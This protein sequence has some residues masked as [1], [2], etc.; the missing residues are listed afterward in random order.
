ME[1]VSIIV[2]VKELEWAE[3]CIE[4]LKPL[5]CKVIQGIQDSF[6]KVVNKIILE[7]TKEIMIMCS[8]RVRPTP[9]DIYKMLDLIEQG[10]G[11]VTLFRL[12]C[13]GFKRDLFRHINLFDERFLI[14]GYEDVC[15]FIRLQEANIAYYENECIPYIK[16]TST[17]VH[18]PGKL[19]SLVHFENKWRIDNQNRTIT[20]K[21][22]ETMDKSGL[23][24]IVDVNLRFKPWSDSHLLYFSSWHSNYKI[25]SNK[26]V[27]G[28]LLIFG[29]TGSLGNKIIQRYGF[30]NK[31]VVYSRD[32]LKQSTLKTMY[33]NL[34]I[35]FVLGDIRDSIRVCEII[36]EINPSV[37]IIASALKQI[38][39]VEYDINEALQT[40]T[41]GI[42]NICRALKMN[43]YNLKIR[44][45]IYISTDKSC[46][47][48]TVYGMTKSL[49]ERIMV[50]YSKKVPEISFV[51][52]RYGNVLDSRGSI[53]PKLKSSTDSQ[54]QLTHPDITRFIM[55]QDQA[56]DLIH[57]SIIHGKTGEI[58][59]PKLKSMRILELI[60]LFA[61]Q[62]SKTIK[63]IGIRGIE[64]L[65][66]E[67]LNREEETRTRDTEKYYIITPP[68][69]NTHNLNTPT[70][71]Y[72]SDNTLY[73]KNELKVYLQF[74][75]Y[76]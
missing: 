11:L 73:T 8:H 45:V 55:T 57:Y 50:E 43:K 37:I 4:S 76:L 30:N 24:D 20:R 15:L 44:K 32:E 66:E 72:S 38:D 51:S 41:N 39:A 34:D 14:G 35:Q 36:C 48:I 16:S 27:G 22:P 31:I 6:S 33:S 46:N 19:Q 17:W 42:L 59:I 62:N 13:F 26:I 25:R 75:N 56:V 10:Y 23:G 18:P 54:L 3:Q 68:Y 69:L 63:I 71:N 74:L 52:C 65:H 1:N 67:L 53:I 9:D 47:P 49:S 70:I 2:F 61:E 5:K 12:A 29:G 60:E 21:L 28:T 40:N 64:K 7:E 58:V